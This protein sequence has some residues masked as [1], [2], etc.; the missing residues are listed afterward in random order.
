MWETITF[1]FEEVFSSPK[2]NRYFLIH[3]VVNGEEVAVSNNKRSLALLII[4]KGNL[5]IMRFG[6]KTTLIVGHCNKRMK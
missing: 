6:P 2:S 5:E 3:T 1:G 4:Q